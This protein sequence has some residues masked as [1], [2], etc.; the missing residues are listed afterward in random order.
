MKQAATTK[1]T[2]RRQDAVVAAL[3]PNRRC[4][5]L[6]SAAKAEVHQLQLFHE[7]GFV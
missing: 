3:P 7:D 2:H 6:L 4:E 5:A 1:R